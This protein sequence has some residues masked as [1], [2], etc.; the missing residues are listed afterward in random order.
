MTAKV[1][2]GLGSNIGD[3]TQ[4][5][6]TALGLIAR[7]NS[8]T[9]K[10]VSS[11]HVTA[12]IGKIDQPDFMNA[13]ALLHTTLAPH[14]LLT[15]L[16]AIEKKMGRVRQ[17]KWGPRIIDLDILTFDDLQLNTP[18]LTLPHPRMHERNF[19]LEPLKEIAIKLPV[20]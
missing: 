19:V 3:R 4:N 9:V 2:L 17:E 13:V 8:T 15:E 6:R 20:Y 7:I 16:L 12:P 10:K 5:L 18:E 11:F 1:Y 14:K